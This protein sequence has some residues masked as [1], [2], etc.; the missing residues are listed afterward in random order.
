MRHTLPE[1]EKRVAEKNEWSTVV[2]TEIA[3]QR[4]R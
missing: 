4:M 2:A 3:A 1:C